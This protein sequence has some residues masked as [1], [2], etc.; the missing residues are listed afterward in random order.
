MT[1]EI[2]D[3]TPVQIYR[4]PPKN[5]LSPALYSLGDSTSNK[6]RKRYSSGSQEL[7]NLRLHSPKK[8]AP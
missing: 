1:P 5:D 8:N 6:K 4:E 7:G 2:Q 3:E